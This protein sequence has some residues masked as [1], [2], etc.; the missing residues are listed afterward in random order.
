MQMSRKRKIEEDSAC[1]SYRK[2]LHSASRELR[3]FESRRRRTRHSPLTNIQLTNAFYIQSPRLHHYPLSPLP[4]GTPSVL[5][6]TA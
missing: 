5:V 1:C 4:K 3:G 2:L 6:P